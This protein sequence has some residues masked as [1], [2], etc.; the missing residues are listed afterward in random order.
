VG[1]DHPVDITMMTVIEVPGREVGPA[2]PSRRI[3]KGAGVLVAMN[4]LIPEKVGA[5]RPSIDIDLTS[6]L[7]TI[8]LIFMMLQF[9]HLEKND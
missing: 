8:T 6:K 3:L 7:M 2:R 5:I 1:E 9:V 4:Q